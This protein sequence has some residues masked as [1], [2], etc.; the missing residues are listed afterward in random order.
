MHIQLQLAIYNGI[1]LKWG[2]GPHHG[3]QVPIM[4]AGCVLF[5]IAELKNEIMLL[6]HMF[7]TIYIAV[8]LLWQVEVGLACM[9]IYSSLHPP[10][11]SVASRLLHAFMVVIYIAI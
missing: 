7:F 2:A 9:H 5:S 6:M 11:I 3:V 10:L 4:G 1:L 8:K